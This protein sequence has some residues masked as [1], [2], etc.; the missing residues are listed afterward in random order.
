MLGVD[1]GDLEATA[2]VEEL[3]QLERRLDVALRWEREEH[4]V[5]P[6][7]AGFQD[8]HGRS[9]SIA[10]RLKEREQ[11][12]VRLPTRDLHSDSDCYTKNLG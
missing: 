10:G 9:S 2:A 7:D 4:Q 3:G 11:Y 12:K 1:K 6:L 5:R 8:R